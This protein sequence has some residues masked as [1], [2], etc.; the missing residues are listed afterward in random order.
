LLVHPPLCDVRVGHKSSSPIQLEYPP[1]DTI[2]RLMRK[3]YVRG[4]RSQFL[5][6]DSGAIYS[7]FG[8]E[9][10]RQ[11]SGKKGQEGQKGAKRLERISCP[12]LPFLSFFA[13]DAPSKTAC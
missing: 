1:Q 2:R 8:A 13:F 9:G 10:R 7:R 4:R 6:S 11:V 12:F 3:S 5:L